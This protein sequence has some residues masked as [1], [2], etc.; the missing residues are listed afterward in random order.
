MV[1]AHANHHLIPNNYIPSLCFDVSLELTTMWKVESPLHWVGFQNVKCG[2][3]PSQIIWAAKSEK[4]TTR[5]FFSLD[6][7]MLCIALITNA[8]SLPFGAF[9]KNRGW[10]WNWREEISSSEIVSSPFRLLSVTPGRT[11]PTTVFN[12]TICFSLNFVYASIASRDSYS[13]TCF[14]SSCCAFNGVRFCGCDG[15]SV[16]SKTA[17]LNLM[18]LSC[19]SWIA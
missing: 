18:R 3:L 9:K 11:A 4:A 1:M 12:T 14:C 13:N 15:N 16:D 5:T 7:K 17:P 8:F 19:I 6:S 2:V 10:R